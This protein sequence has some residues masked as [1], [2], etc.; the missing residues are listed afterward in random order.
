[1]K[2][3]A[4]PKVLG[5]ADLTLFSICAILTIDTLASA[6][7]M[8]VSWF[9]WW[10]ITLVLF[11]VPYGL[12][13]AELGGAWPAEGG[14]YV[15]VR[16]GM[17]PRWGSLAAWFYW[18]N[19]AYWV[20]SVYLVFAGTFHSIFLRDAL[21]P[22]IAAGSGATWL[23]TGIAIVV[24]WATVLL[25]IL[26][27]SVAKWVPNVGAVVKAAIFGGL[28]GLGIASI[29]SGRPPA[30]AFTL[31]AVLPHFGDSL[32]FLPVLVYNV[33]GFEL[34]N[35][36]G[37]EMKDP[38]R[39]VPWVVLTSG[40][41]VAVVYTLGVLGIL[42]AV[43]LAQLSLVTGTWD[44]LVVLGGQGA[45]GQTLVLVLGIGFLYSC[46]ANIVTWSLGANRVAAAAAAEG[47]LP[48][49][50]GRLHPRY[51]T[52]HTA[53]VVMGFVSTALLVGNALLSARADNV[54]WM[55]FRLS[56]VCFLVSY[57]LLFPAFLFLRYRQPERRRPYRMPGGMGVAWTATVL[58]WTFVAVACVLFFKPTSGAEASGTGW[59]ESLLLLA[60]ALATLGLGLWFVPWARPAADPTRPSPA[61]LPT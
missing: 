43:P 14:L 42:L 24:T 57:L 20:P 36:A 18:I 30:N 17:G 8:G 48:A 32:A 45:A 4:L 1:M 54:F 27:L 25:G 23:Q 3:E 60:E 56:G 29:V 11:F 22:S 39:D 15:W 13:T 53:F 44:A 52:P 37:E 33:L 47:A 50:L 58:C 2:G 16:E 35:G 40:L 38:Q 46:V 34:M 9:A 49:L 10:A 5:R 19:N 21:P 61:T 7:S 28:G 31:E 55:I 6:A 26:R 51:R 12:I 59:K 41:V